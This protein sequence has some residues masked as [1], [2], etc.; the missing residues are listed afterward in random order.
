MS[1][2][3]SHYHV[4]QNERVIIL[5]QWQQHCIHYASEKRAH[6]YTIADGSFRNVLISYQRITHCSRS[7]SPCL[8][9]PKHHARWGQSFKSASN[10]SFMHN[11]TAQLDPATLHTSSAWHTP[12]SLRLLNRVSMGDTL[13]KLAR[14]LATWRALQLQCTVCHSDGWGALAG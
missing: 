6:S 7:P 14:S 4:Y 3:P 1:S 13:S 11:P 12:V 8:A 5:Q 10:H 9:W 2:T